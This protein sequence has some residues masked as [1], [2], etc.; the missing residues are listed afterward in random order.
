VHFAVTKV[1]QYSKAAFPTQ[2]VYGPTKTPSLQLVTCGGAFDYSTGHYLSNIVV[3]SH[4]VSVSGHV[5]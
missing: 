3:F 5:K 1:V 4:L 2:L